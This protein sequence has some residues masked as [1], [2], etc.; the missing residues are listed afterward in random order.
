MKNRLVLM[1]LIG[2][3]WLGDLLLCSCFGVVVFGLMFCEVSMLWWMLLV[4]F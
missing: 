1:L 3:L 2:R 4:R